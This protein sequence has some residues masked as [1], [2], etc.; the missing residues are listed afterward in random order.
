MGLLDGHVA[1][2]TGASRGIGAEIARRFGAEGAAVAVAA[3]TAEPGVS[4]LEGTISETAEQIQAAG[5]SAIA[6]TADL[7]RPEDRERLVAETASRSAS[8]TSS[9]TTRPSRTSP[10]SRTSLRSGTR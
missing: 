7:A 4:R 6:I 10:G 1:I 2:V 9:S 8:P 3:R 5:G